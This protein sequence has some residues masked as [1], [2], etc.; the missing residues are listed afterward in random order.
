MKPRF[1]IPFLLMMCS[2]A[3]AAE[4]TLPSVFSDHMVLQRSIAAPI[5][6]TAEPGERVV[7]KFDGQEKTATADGI[8]DWEVKLDPLHAGGPETLTVATTK[9][10]T[11]SDVLVGEVWL[12]SGQSNMAYAA[13]HFFSK[14]NLG[15]YRG[16]LNLLN[17]I[18][19]GPYSQIRMINT[20]DKGWIT[21]TPGN[22]INFSALL[23]SFG[24]S[25]NKKLNV[26]V[27]LIMAAR[28]GMP[29]GRFVTQAAIRQDPACQEEIAKASEP[30]ALAEADQK[31]AS[32]L[33]KYNVAMAAWNELP[34]EQKKIHKAPY[35]PFP[36]VRPGDLKGARV[37][38][39]HDQLIKPFL[40]YAIRGVL[41]DQGESGTDL[42]G[43]DQVTL[44]RVLI[45]SWRQEWKLADV[46]GTSVDFP[47][48]YIQKP[49]GGGCAFDY[50]DTVFAPFA[51][52]FSPLP[53]EVPDDGASIEMFQR[54]ASVPHTFMVQSSDLGS[55]LHPFNKSGYGARAAFV[56]LGTVYGEDVETSGPVYASH[57]M[58]GGKVRVSFTHVGQ[59]LV[60]RNGNKLQGFAL[61]GADK[62][63]V[64]ADAV[65]EGNT[66]LV[67]SPQIPL[68]AFVR[69]AWSINRAW[70]NL[71]NK[72]GLPAL[73]FRTDEDN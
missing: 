38:E 29:S 69:Y 6:G 21:A 36:P 27:G 31:Y 57:K 42:P 13:S 16:D 34:E 5:W 60:F 24:L 66:V 73:S 35:K 11:I 44:M 33:Q 10:I 70:A 39:L 3:R 30:A 9:T 7:V 52:K 12:G 71:F 62:K 51:D 19:A 1:L 68:P 25:L 15:Q 37:G 53:P 2:S 14:S 4:L 32:D 46:S 43:V 61:A 55:G 59:G 23:Q 72:D 64:W 65:V 40:G 56:A 8:G 47:F 26:P 67:S 18:N 22:L 50:H 48:I 20:G 41:W 45:Q 17:A 54:I 63:F 58:E 28:P 49:S